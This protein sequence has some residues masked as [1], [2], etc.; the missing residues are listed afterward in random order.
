MK[1][2][3]PSRRALAV[4]AL[5]AALAALVWFGKAR[6]WDE[7]RLPEQILFQETLVDLSGR[8][9]RGAVVDEPADAPV[10]LDEVVPKSDGP[11]GRRLGIIA[12]PRSRIRFHAPVPR[13]ATLEF[14]M[15][16]QGTGIRDREADGVVF[17]VGA[18]AYLVSALTSAPVG[19]TTAQRPQ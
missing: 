18:V 11:H 6:W 15:G 3:R 7:F 2:R 4:A 9:D 14:A 17:S 10:R 16:V 8:F 5:A 12:P 1:S 13:E 19:Q